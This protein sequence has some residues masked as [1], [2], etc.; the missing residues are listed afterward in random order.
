MADPIHAVLVHEKPIIPPPRHG[1]E[2][3]VHDNP[4]ALACVH[5][6]GFATPMQGPSAFFSVRLFYPS[7]TTQL[8][9]KQEMKKEKP[10]TGN[11]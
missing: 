5:C 3:A 7:D 8:D 2:T 11:R 6:S 4:T 1:G 10:A 9:K